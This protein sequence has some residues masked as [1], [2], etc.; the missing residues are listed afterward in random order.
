MIA[1]ELRVLTLYTVDRFERWC[2]SFPPD[3]SLSWGS[4][5]EQIPPLDVLM[6]WHAY[7]LN[8]GFVQSFPL[9]LAALTKPTTPYA[10]R[11]YAEDCIR[12]PILAGL[13]QLDGLLSVFGVCTL[14]QNSTHI[15][16]FDAVITQAEQG[17]I[18]ALTGIQVSYERASLWG[19]RT[20]MPFDPMDAIPG[21]T[22]RY[23]VCPKCAGYVSQRTFHSWWMKFPRAEGPEAL[24]S[25][26]GTGYLQLRAHVTCACTFEITREALAVHKLVKVL[27]RDGTDLESLLACVS[28]CVLIQSLT[29][30]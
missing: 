24:F 13:R 3:F 23:V 10:C 1:D 22:H 6:V 16:D 7:M 25:P 8:P 9:E 21:L 26:G 27:A 18:A 29:P 30:W 17:E 2:R 19:R 5:E 12:L 14:P 28:L 15:S 4:V 11:W 20:S